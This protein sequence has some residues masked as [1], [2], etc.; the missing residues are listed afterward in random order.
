MAERR[1]QT[2]TGG[3]AAT[4]GVICGGVA[5]SVGNPGTDLPDGWSWTALHEVARLETG[6]TPSRKQ[7]AYWDGDIPWIGIRDATANHGRRIVDTTQHVTQAGIDNSSARVLPMDTICLSRTASVGYVVEMGVPMAT[8]QDFV[9]WVCG[10]KLDHR[11]LKYVLLAEHNHL[12]RFAS[13]TT[14]QTIYFPE[15]KAFHVALPALEEQR[16]IAGLLGAL[17]DKIDLNQRMTTH[18]R[19][20]FEA[21]F[22]SWISHEMPASTEDLGKLAELTKGV[23]YR[24][25]DLDESSTTAMVTLKSVGRGGVY[26]R[27]G[28][29]PYAGKYKSTQVLLE[30]DLAVAQ[31]D[32][33]QAADLIGRVIEVGPTDEFDTLV[34]SL[35]LIAVRPT[36]PGV[37]KEFLLGSL[38]QPS[39]RH[40]CL[41]RANGT[42]VLHLAKDALPT[43][44]V[45]LPDG[46]S[47]GGFSDR[48]APLLALGRTAA[49]ENVT[50]TELR[51][52]LLPKLLSG[53]LRVLEAEAVVEGVA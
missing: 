1:R 49:R 52:A 42:T 22:S 31:T 53:E 32:V 7:P 47:I 26:R 16:R 39:F 3:R 38:L 44:Q 34:A 33:T 5:L 8:S 30:G 40:H 29:K 4:S 2:R 15:V 9:N 36:A 12:H 14:H 13:G 50:L 10:P 28:L 48:A 51:D 43:Y 27:D 17:D 23:S 41:A 20:L 19:E 21:E 24:R 37:T 18:V 45:P 35:D 46:D 6:H 25:A 11:Y